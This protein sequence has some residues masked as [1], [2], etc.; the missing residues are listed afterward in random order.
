MVK[1]TYGLISYCL[2]QE[3]AGHRFLE[4][5]GSVSACCVGVCTRTSQNSWEAEVFVWCESRRIIWDWDLK[6]T[7]KRCLGA[8]VPRETVWG[9]YRVRAHQWDFSH[10]LNQEDCVYNQPDINLLKLPLALWGLMYF[11]HS[12]K[13]RLF[14]QIALLLSTPLWNSMSRHRHVV[15]VTSKHINFPQSVK[16]SALQAFLSLRGKEKRFLWASPGCT[17]AHAGP[18][19]LR[20]EG[21]SCGLLQLTICTGLINTVSQGSKFFSTSLS[22]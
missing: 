7:S 20:E 22:G 6:T 19:L 14:N 1:N 17:C 2:K 9:A 21:R 16:A 10:P 11:S 3:W 4:N 5:P 8:Y 12:F 13:G 18:G 15:R